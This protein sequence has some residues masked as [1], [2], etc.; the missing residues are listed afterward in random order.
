MSERGS[1]A[2]RFLDGLSK[3][4]KK[5]LEDRLRYKEEVRITRQQLQAA[6]KS[7]KK[8]KAANLTQSAKSREWHDLADEWEK[9]AEDRA[10]EIKGMQ[11]E[12]SRMQGVEAGLRE[13]NEQRAKEIEDLRRAL[14]EEKAARHAE[15]EKLSNSLHGWKEDYDFQQTLLKRA[16]IDTINWYKGSP[17]FEKHLSRFAA[18]YFASGMQAGA[19]QVVRRTPDA[20]E[21]ELD[22]ESTE[23]VQFPKFVLAD[24]PDEGIEKE[25]FVGFIPSA[26]SGAKRV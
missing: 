14:D 10:M 11:L 17:Y 19:K 8:A 1:A 18:E 2:M 20:I 12:L 7:L 4:E 6:E 23:G 24:Y 3:D 26:P 25:A 5:V 13:Q 16:K 22:Y 9:T 15:V 21:L